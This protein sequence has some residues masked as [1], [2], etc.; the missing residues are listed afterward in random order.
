MD[1]AVVGQVAANVVIEKQV[2]RER[3]AT[4]HFARHWNHEFHRFHR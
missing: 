1:S 2:V 3:V 4:A